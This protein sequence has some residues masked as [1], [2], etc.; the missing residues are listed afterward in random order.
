[1][2]RL[3]GRP[4]QV[5]ATEEPPLDQATPQPRLAVGTN[6]HVKLDPT[7]PLNRRFTE[8]RSLAIEIVEQLV[9]GDQIRVFVFAPEPVFAWVDPMLIEHVVSSL[10]ASA[11]QCSIT[12]GSI[13]LRVDERR[14]AACISVSDNALVPQEARAMTTRARDDQHMTVNREIVEAHGGSIAIDRRRSTSTHFELPLACPPRRQRLVG[15][16]GL[17]VGRALPH[18]RELMPMLTAEGMGIERS[19]THHDALRTIRAR[20]PDTVVI[21]A[22]FPGTTVALPEL[23]SLL[24]DALVVVVTNTPTTRFRSREPVILVNPI[25]AGELFAV[26]TRRLARPDMP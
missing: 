16:S 23:R 3:D 8:L 10:L 1:M 11:L 14:G 4:R 17:L 26:I 2:G 20:R 21:D 18:V 13:V 5:T 24:P 12:G 25:D 9:A 22:D 15:R 19:R 7:G 6:R